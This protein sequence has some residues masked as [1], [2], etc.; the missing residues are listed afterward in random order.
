MNKATITAAIVSAFLLAGCEVIS[1]NRVKPIRPVIMNLEVKGGELVNDKGPNTK[2]IDFDE[3]LRKGCFFA[4]QGEVLE[5]QFHLLGNSWRLTQLQIC[6][7]VTKPDPDT[8]TL[9]DEQQSEWLVIADRKLSLVPGDGTVNLTHISDNLRKLTIL[10]IN[11]QPG[12][13][14]YNLRA[15]KVGSPDDCVT[16]DPGGTNTG[17]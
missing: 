10:D 9:N 17:R 5:L 3:P 7:G 14:T 12:N 6:A 13:Y 8:C 4:E 1:V 15:C 2:C 16:M 11:G